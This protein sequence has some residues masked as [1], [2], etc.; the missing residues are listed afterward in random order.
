M[1]EPDVLV[2]GGG[3]AGLTCAAFLA[4]QG[5]HV[6]LLERDDRLG[7]LARSVKVDGWLI[8]ANFARTDGLDPGDP[9]VR[10]LEHLGVLERL[11]PAP[12]A[13]ACEV[14][15]D[16]GFRLVVP[17]GLEAAREAFATAF[18]ADERGVR[19]SLAVFEKLATEVERLA[20]DSRSAALR[21][22]GFPF[23]YPA[24]FRLRGRTCADVLR[25][26]VR[27][28]RAR[29]A[30]AALSPLVGTSTEAIGA[31]A[32]ALAATAILRRPMALP[33]GGRSLVQALADAARSADV[34]VRLERPALSVLT[35]GHRALGVRTEDGDLR[36][37]IVV[38]NV[39]ALAAFGSLVPREALYAGYLQRLGQMRVAASACILLLAVRI[40]RAELDAKADL[41]FVHAGDDLEAHA[42]ALDEDSVAGR[43]MAL[44]LHA[45][46]ADGGP[47]GD[48]AG[49]TLLTA[50]VPD[51]VARWA[52]LDEAR[53]AEL[54]DETKS[55][56][57]ARLSFLHAGLSGR[58]AASRLL[59]PLDLADWS[60]DPEGSLFGWEQT[61]SQ[62]G[63][64]RLE[65]TTPVDRL[66]LAG[67]WT[68]PGAGYGAT[69]LSGF[70]AGLRAAMA[71]GKRVKM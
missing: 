39:P 13:T 31:T 37:K 57:L 2:V 17:A 34:D 44:A 7:G 71:L 6:T 32:Y 40:P 21:F 70:L 61:P 15:I 25:G 23:F 29:L 19:K 14:R 59:T 3:I 38:L 12:L 41:V 53:R 68:Y 65:A 18:P 24:L 51:R 54:I 63:S 43:T 66:L 22:L 1:A 4:R 45:A 52:E 62:S 11:H 36:A 49:C 47:S 5:V 26:R 10:I 55:T 42:L 46:A 67:S 48:D 27:G 30:L 20:D 64:Q 50:A 28:R 9:K 8:P 33:G 56:L 69:M 58:I 16:D 60:G 35:D